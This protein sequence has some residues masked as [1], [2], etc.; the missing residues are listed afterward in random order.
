MK[1]NLLIDSANDSLFLVTF[2][3]VI[4]KPSSERKV[5]FSEENDGRSLRRYSIS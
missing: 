2:G 4:F 5:A 3:D 1:E